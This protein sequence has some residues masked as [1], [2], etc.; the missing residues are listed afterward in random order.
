MAFVLPEKVFVDRGRTKLKSGSGICSSCIW[1]FHLPLLMSPGLGQEFAAKSKIYLRRE[2]SHTR[3]FHQHILI[4]DMLKAAN[5]L[6]P[7]K[8]V[9][10]SAHVWG[11]SFLH[12]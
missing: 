8:A 7:E 9:S 1:H 12:S 10:F 2:D 5:D 6:L 11:F 3:I 4:Q